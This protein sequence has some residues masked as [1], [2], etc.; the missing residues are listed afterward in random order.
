M[1][2]ATE[3]A[4]GT[5]FA[6]EVRLGVVLYGGVSLA[7]YMNGTTN[8]LHRAVRGRGVYYLIKH[9][10]DA[11]ITVDVASGASAGGIN[12]IFLSFAL[13]NGRE[14]GTCADLW[15]RDGDLGGLLRSLEGETA[16]SVLDSEH[17]R[18]VLENGFRVMWHNES[19]P[20]EP[21]RPSATR[22]LDLFVTG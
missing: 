17:Y 4:E 14:F 22:E 15:R 5:E 21:E 9:L 12:G 19:H 20:N 3:A 13:A 8:E 7:I 16:P 6:H 18:A 11:D 2:D 10:L 1:S